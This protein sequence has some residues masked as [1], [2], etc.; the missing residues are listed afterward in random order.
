MQVMNLH[1]KVQQKWLGAALRIKM[2]YYQIKPL[3]V[4]AQNQGQKYFAINHR[5]PF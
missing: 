2:A 4:H 3:Q 1:L 5:K